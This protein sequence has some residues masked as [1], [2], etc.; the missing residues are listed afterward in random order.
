[1]LR[2]HSYVRMVLL[3]IIAACLSSGVIALFKE[4]F[5]AGLTWSGLNPDGG[6]PGFLVVIVS[7]IAGLLARRDA[8]KKM[9]TA[10]DAL[11]SAALAG[12]FGSLFWYLLHGSYFA[13]VKTQPLISGATGAFFVARIASST[14]ETAWQSEQASDAYASTADHGNSVPG[15]R[16]PLSAHVK[17][18]SLADA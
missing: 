8:S 2:K 3:A 14:V 1:M 7:G 13:E 9:S 11:E 4:Q 10:R 5:A 12:I 18:D 16:P 6:G 15:Q 17:E